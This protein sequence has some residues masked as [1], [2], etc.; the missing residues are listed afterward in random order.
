MRHCTSEF[1][2]QIKTASLHLIGLTYA[3][4][5]RNEGWWFAHLGTFIERADKTSRILDVHNQ[6][7]PERGV[8]TNIS[9]DEVLGWSAILRSCSAW[10]AYKSIHGA[11]VS[12]RLVAE[13]LLLNEDFPRFVRLCVHE[14]NRAVRRISGVGEGRFS[15]DVEKLAGRLEAELRFN[16]IDEIFDHGLHLCLDQLQSRLNDIGAALFDDYIFQQFD[17]IGADVIVQQ[18]EQQQQ[19]T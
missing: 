19:A 2:Q 5:I 18:E 11:E 16:T 8:P 13:F 15:S 7:L 6:T 1:F 14:M 17:N 9:Q 12:P 10:D 4:L 3:T